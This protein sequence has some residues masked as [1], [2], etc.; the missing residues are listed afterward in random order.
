MNEKKKERLDSAETLRQAWA[1]S[2]FVS[3]LGQEF[4]K[5]KNAL[6]GPN[7]LITM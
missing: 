6:A 1:L 7:D 4:P 2:N 5:M 3:M